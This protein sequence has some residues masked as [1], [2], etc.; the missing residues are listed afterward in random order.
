MKRILAVSL[1]VLPLLVAAQ[2]KS[3][4][5]W[6]DAELATFARAYTLGTPLMSYDT[7]VGERVAYSGIAVQLFRAPN[8]LQLLNPWA[9]KAYG[10]AEQNLDFDPI[11]KR[12]AGLRFFAIRF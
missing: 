4:P 1:V 9:P 3:P 10:P 2:T 8:P 7:I 12:P 6:S 11:T 5:A